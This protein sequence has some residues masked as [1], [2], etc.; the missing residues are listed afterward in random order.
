MQSRKEKCH[1]CNK[2][3]ISTKRNERDGWTKYCSRKCIGESQRK[4]W[5]SI[6][7][8]C[9]GHFYVAKSH[10]EREGRGKQ[11][12]FCSIKCKSNWQSEN[13]NFE[14]NHNWMGG[15]FIRKDG[16][17]GINVG[18]GK[19]RL[20]HDIIIEKHIGRRIIKG[21]DVHHINGIR[22]DNRIENLQ[23]C[24]KSEHTK[25]HHKQSLGSK[26][27]HRTNSPCP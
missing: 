15:R 25:I 8:F 10:L 18:K 6:C 2:E 21:E 14:N 16:Y 7:K 22:T 5:V 19:Y 9:K 27:K 24:T 12:T 13:L 11:G 4:G 3:F 1:N 17:I 20:E 23:L 26:T